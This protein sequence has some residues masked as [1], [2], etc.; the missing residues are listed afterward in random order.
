MIQSFVRTMGQLKYCA[1]SLSV[2]A[3]GLGIFFGCAASEPAG[4]KNIILFVSDGCGPASFTMAR[5]FAKATGK[6]ETLFLDDMLVGAIRTYSANREVTDSAAGATAFSCG[7]KANHQAVGL[8]ANGD[9][10][11]TVME[12]AEELGMRT[13]VV[14]TKSITDATPAAF[15]AHVAHRYDDEPEIA[16]QQLEGGFDLLFGGGLQSF[17]PN[18]GGGRRTDGRN[19]IDEAKAKGYNV[20]TDLEGWNAA[21]SLPILALMGPG[22]LAYEIDRDPA[23]QPTFPDAVSKAIGLLDGDEDGFFLLAEGSM[24][25]IGGHSNDAAAH[26]HDILAFDEAVKAA[27]DFARKDGN[28]LVVSVSDHETGGLTVGRSYR[29]HPL[30]LAKVTASHAVVSAEIQEGS[31]SIESIIESH[32]GI[33]DLTKDEIQRIESA[34]SSNAMNG[35]LA[36]IVSDRILVDWASFGHTAVDI[37]VYAFGP[38]S[39]QFRGNNDNTM[40]GKLLLSMLDR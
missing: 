5:D 1:R 38:G 14:V 21:N 18:D 24:I 39:A 33:T 31:R 15:T 6:R 34:E 8:A 4:P 16:I 32:F 20:V 26:V 9:T 11:Q 3:V 2:L 36:A 13:G 40:I 37:N 12:R 28:T 10:V 23:V 25:D 22:N 19:L 29:W 30:E 35:A 27:V 7:V 17:L